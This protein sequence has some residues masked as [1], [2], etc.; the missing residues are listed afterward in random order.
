MSITKRRREFLDHIYR[1]YNKT[2]LPVHYSEVAKAI[3]VSKWTAYDVLKELENQGLVK[4]T[5][6]MNENEAGRS[7]VVFSPTELAETFFQKE[8]REIS[9]LEEWNNIHNQVIKAVENPQ[10]LPLREAINQTIHLMKDVEVKLEFCAY[11][12]SI[13][14]LYLNSLGKQVKSLTVNVINASK[15]PK[16]QLTVFVGAVVGMIIQSVSDDLS[17]EMIQL[18][19]QFFNN[20]NQLNSDEMQLLIELIEYC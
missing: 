13:L 7:M 5:Y 14:L 9:N 10:N 15:E 18:I 4:R 12:L 1:Q 11:F 17:P 16:I 19:Q 20:V 2:S 6:S 3:G 8:R